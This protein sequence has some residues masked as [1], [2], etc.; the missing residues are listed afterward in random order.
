MTMR[1]SGQQ[2]SRY[3]IRLKVFC[4]L[5]Q[6]HRIRLLQ[7]RSRVWSQCSGE[8]CFIFDQVHESGFR[9]TPE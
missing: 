9:R 5:S 8:M 4:Q 2:H 1:K 6:G 3:S 7:G